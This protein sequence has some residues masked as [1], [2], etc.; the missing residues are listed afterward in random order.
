MKIHPVVPFPAPADHEAGEAAPGRR[1]VQESL[2]AALIDAIVS[3]EMPEG[4]TLPNEVELTDRFKVSR[5][6]LREAMQ[7]LGT[8]GLVRSRTRAGTIVLPSDNWNFLDPMILDAAL[9]FRADVTFYASLL[10]ARSLLEPEAAA[11]AATRASARQVAQIEGAFL[12]MI[13]ANARDNEA[14]SRADLEFH[15]AIIAAS[16]NWIYR[17]FVS[18]IRAA[19]LAS[20]RLTNRHTPS[21]DHVIRAHRAVLEAIRLRKPQEARAAMEA[22]MVTARSEL[23][24]I[25]QAQATRD[26]AAR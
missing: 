16:G 5:T 21:H 4:S 19:L 6:A 17:H 20:F 11:L 10:E 9:R 15:S 22:L 12:R 3:G 26:R 24:E 14:W 7:V 13:E 18:A 2:L 1:R 23:G 8:Q 25:L